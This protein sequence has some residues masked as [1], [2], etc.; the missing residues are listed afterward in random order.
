MKIPYSWLKDFVDID[1]GVEELAKTLVSV[2]LEVEAMSTRRIPEGV[3]IARITA[4]AAHPNA[5]KLSLCTVDV[6]ESEPVSVVC[7]APNVKEGMVV[8]LAT[9]GTKLTPEFTVKKARIRGTESFGMLCSEKELGISDDHSG[10]MELSGDYAPGVS[11]S[12]AFPPQEVI[13]LE[14]TPDRGDCLSMLGVAR[15]VACAYGKPLRDTVRRPQ[16]SGDSVDKHISVRIDDPQRCPRYMGR[17]IRNVTLAE[18]PAWLKDRLRSAG[19]RPINNIVDVTNYILLHF[20]QPMH[21]FDYDRIGD[22]RIEI[23]LAGSGQTFTTLDGAER[24]LQDSDLLICDGNGPVALAGVMGGAGSEISPTTTNVF[25]ECAYFDPPGIRRTSK[26][27]GLSTDSSYRFERGVDPAKGLE[28]ALD[29]AAE[30]IREL[31]G[32]EVVAGVVDECPEPLQPRSIAI[33]PARSARVLGVEV[34]AG[35]IVSYLEGLGM[36]CTDRTS[37]SLTFDVPLFR[38]DLAAEIDLIEEVGRLYGY[39]NIPLQPY[40][41]VALMNNPSPYEAK[42]DKLR[43]S[44]AYFGLNE[45]V[46]NSMTSETLRSL[47]TPDTAPVQVRN[48]LSPE[49]AQM[50][51][52]LMGGHLQVLAFNLN[53]KNLDNK[54]FEL[55]KIFAHTGNDAELPRERTVVGIVIQG[56]YIPA[57]WNTKAVPASFYVLR[58]I[59]DSFVQHSGIGE[60]SYEP[61]TEGF[62]CLE[63]E[64]AA[65][66]GEAGVRG[67]LGRIRTDVAG[68]FGIDTNVYCAQ[69]DVTEFLDTPM[70]APRYRPA[71]RFPAVERDYCFVMPTSVRAAK[72]ADQ[73]HAVSD[74]VEHVQPFD[75]YRGEKL[76]QGRK[77]ITYAVR[78]RSTEKTLSD[79]EAEAAATAI[80][81]AVTTKFGAEL[82]Q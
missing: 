50:R 33:R 35:K 2:G 38:H 25:L 11:L 19:L 23:K 55:G 57:S 26:R 75:L 62:P 74:L 27:L 24:Q 61:D 48:P 77:S 14:I 40:G 58:G 20:G 63:G 31:G 41:R 44:L 29:T 6:G 36:S 45:I 47:F 34:P 60:V 22:R 10:I 72:V 32:G 7:G 43:R 64:K 18:S 66:R 9:V 69:L 28:D 71:P 17:L 1:V 51:T 67:A 30:M 70:S 37:D 5:D 80:I 65:I 13:E 68:H 42:A 76:G 56:D 4:L 52:T 82:R 53:R 81:D 73:I 8:A 46:T 79:T 59:V 12:E 78:L 3:K 49:M 39:D 21:A 15:E 16:E 54:F